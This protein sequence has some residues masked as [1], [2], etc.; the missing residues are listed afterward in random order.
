MHSAL[1]NDPCN[2]IIDSIF[3]VRVFIRLQ[4]KICFV[5]FGIYPVL[6][7]VDSV[8]RIGGA[9]LQQIHI[10]KGLLRRGYNV[11]YIT[12]DYGQEDAKII[13]GIVI[14]KAFRED[15]GIPVFRFLYPRLYKI[16]MSL[17]KADADIYY[18]RAAG[19]MPSILAIFCRLYKKKFI[20]AAAHDTDFIPSQLL[21][22]NW[23]DKFL[24]QIGLRHAHHILV[25][26]NVQKELLRRNFG[27]DGTVIRNFFDSD[28]VPCNNKNEIILWVATIRSWKRPL[29]FIQ[30][31]RLFPNENFV[32]IGGKDSSECDLYHAVEMECSLLSNIKFIGFQPLFETEKY[33]D[34]CKI[35]VNTSETE[36]FPNTFLQAWSRGV[37]VI[38]YV[39]P[40]DLIKMYR[41]GAVVQSDLELANALRLL[42]GSTLQSSKRIQDYFREYHSLGVID[43]YIPLLENLHANS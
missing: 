38:S 17:L 32:M 30:L 29:E 35:F 19:F 23:R 27:L 6:C 20:F 26:S 9:E 1:K 10:G 37:P 21:I 16:W 3:V 41:L 5:A 2:Y 11:C 33:F 22:A 34:K 8:E 4:M 36:G 31:A 7:N 14:Y 13:D 25:Q 12:C 18:C 15:V 43:Q 40:D 24:Y 42:L 28:I 39:D